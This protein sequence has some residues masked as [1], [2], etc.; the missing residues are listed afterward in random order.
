MPT[1]PERCASRPAR[2]RFLTCLANSECVL[3]RQLDAPSAPGE[4]LDAVAVPW[5]RRA[6]TALRFALLV[7][8]AWALRREL[9]GIEPN[10]LFARFGSYGP[11][12]ALLGLGCTVASFF[13]LGIIELVALRQAQPAGKRNM[14]FVEVRP[15]DAMTT[16]FVANAFSQSIGL[17]LLTGAAVR[18]RA[19]GRH[20]LDAV[21]VARVTAFATLTTTLG[22]LAASA[23]A[24]STST[25][26]LH[27]RGY[28]IPVRLLGGA[29]ALLVI[30]Y[31]LW[32]A[33]GHAA[34]VGRGRW[35][36]T[37]PT[38][39]VAAAQ[40]ALSTL[41]WLL[42]GAVLFAFV[43][44]SLGVGYWTLMRA[45]MM[46]QTVGVA[47]HVPGGAG[48]LEVVLLSLLSATASAGERTTV[49]ASL[50]M[51]RVVYYLVPLI[52]AIIVAGAAELRRS[53]R[54]TRALEG[55]HVG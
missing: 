41:D 40:V 20:G 6:T 31:V 42:A 37:R 23:A 11:R 3:R 28:S 44:A 30:A 10:E 16:A 52:A 13:I 26:P 35:R 34:A 21:A 38:L 55:A 4:I 33:L 54:A 47:S 25:V 1:S 29:L 17:A 18:L 8:A 51:F 22:L 15:A 39:G 53:V 14:N 43:P 27:A 32:A 49:V 5:R 36:L 19:Y 2:A 50:V 9:V 12:H 48:V 45:F 24:L 7:A 46:A